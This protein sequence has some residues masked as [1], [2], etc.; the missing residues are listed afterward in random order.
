M[1]K[2]GI[3]GSCISQDV[4][5]TF[6]NKNYKELFQVIFK[7]ARLSVISVMNP[8]ISYNHED[9]VVLPENPVNKNRTDIMRNDLSKTFFR[10]MEL[11]ID[12]L[13]LDE[14]FE[15]FFGVVKYQDSYFTH[16]TWDYS[17][18]NFFKNI[19][20]PEILNIQDNPE[21]YFEL[22]KINI[23]KFFKSIE[24]EYPN[25]KI[26]LNKVK[27]VNLVLNKNGEKVIKDYYTTFLHKINPNLEKI[28][29]YIEENY[30]NVIILD[31][32]NEMKYCDENHIWGLGPVHYNKE[33]Y[34]KFFEELLK[35]IVKNNIYETFSDENEC[36]VYEI[37]SS[38]FIEETNSNVLELYSKIEFLKEPKK[39]EE[40]EKEISS[41]NTQ[42][43]NLINNKMIITNNDYDKKIIINDVLF[44]IPN[45]FMIENNIN[46]TAI[47][48]HENF[49]IELNC[50][51]PNNNSNLENDLNNFIS[52]YSELSIESNDLFIN[53][54]L[55]KKTIGVNKS[56][57]Y[58]YRY[59][60]NINNTTF[61]IRISDFE[62]EDL[63]INMIR[64][65]KI[66]KR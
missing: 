57:Y 33:Y 59:W 10:M 49:F 46:R 37:F 15:V 24:S 53:N 21:E 47:I 32:R 22:W 9:I 50:F 48:K 51:N 14:Y 52:S 6:Y 45:G 56:S 62:L 1:I 44:E 35:T 42:I 63:V 19:K 60:I 54:I 20:H 28:E 66:L 36:V 41:L 8:P 27:V 34:N 11:G 26:V 58:D 23:D 40:N 2:I 64:T 39:I 65:S 30:K 12:Y 38:K 55:I 5:R 13:I 17:Y 4:F 16:N 3:M 29:N 61:N 18:S 25:L 7:T 43:S 31:L